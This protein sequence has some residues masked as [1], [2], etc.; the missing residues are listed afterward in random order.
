MSEANRAA[1]ERPDDP[2]GALLHRWFV[3]YNPFYLLSAALVLG[4]LT[5]VSRGIARDAHPLQFMGVAL[6]AEVYAWSL[7]GG[8]ALLMRGGQRRP[9]VLLGLLA[10]VYQSDLTLHVE[11][12]G[13]LGVAGAAPAALWAANF[14]AKLS[15]L[16]AALRVRLDRGATRVVGFGA[17]GLAALPFAVYRLKADGAGDALALF[18]FALLALLPRD[19]G[20]GATSIEPLDGWGR[21][22]LRRVSLAAFSI[23][24]LAL[25]LH[26][27]FWSAQVPVSMGRVFLAVAAFFVARQRSEARA[28]AF[29]AGLVLVSAVARER[30]SDFAALAA[31]TLL[32]R[33]FAWLRVERPES[34]APRTDEPSP[35]R[36]GEAS[37]AQ[38]VESDEA[39]LFEKVS[40]AERL[41]LLP[42]ALFAAYLAA[43]LWGYRGGPLPDHIAAL[44]AS[45]VALSAVGFRSGGRLGLAF[46]SASLAHALAASGLVPRPRG[47]IEWGALML[48]AGF[49]LLGGS[50]AVSSWLARRAQPRAVA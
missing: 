26:V 30:V 17:L 24:G 2:W 14:F 47:L 42:G 9:A 10:I 5:M 38:P 18:V 37:A 22:V 21:V 15:A 34:P 44:D 45:F 6:L 46:S 40:A 4:G 1:A 16:A 23:W 31:L 35:Y 33:A 25:A 19:M 13:L 41:R 28:W 50:L 20:A 49:L 48:A 12:C 39:P 36:A 8:A 11:T 43:W 7:I 27:L 29:A 32:Y 3:Q